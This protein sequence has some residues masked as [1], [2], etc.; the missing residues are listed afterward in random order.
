MRDLLREEWEDGAVA[1]GA[2]ALAIAATTVRPSFA[3]PLF[4]GGL[5]VAGR[6][7]LADSRRSDLLDRLVIDRDAYAIPGVRARAEKEAAMGNRRWLSRC[8]RSRL[9]FA[10]NPR[11]AANADQLAPLADE[12]V[13]PTLEL[14]PA[15]AVACSK[16]LMDPVSSPLINSGL[17]AE[18]VRSRLVQIRAGFH[19]RVSSPDPSDPEL[20][21]PAAPANGCGVPSPRRFSET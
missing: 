4:I 9:E 16:L 15:C 21:S 2:F 20:T 7:V 18:D 14:D 5:F 12:L 3:L 8:I 19:P 10:E 11:F 1:V 17:P 6:A 13:D